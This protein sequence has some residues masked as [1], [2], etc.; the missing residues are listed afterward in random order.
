MGRRRT[1]TRANVRQTTGKSPSKWKAIKVVLFT[2][3]SF[4]FTWIPY[5][6]AST[7]YV[8]CDPQATPEFCTS[9]RIA[10]ASPLA[11]LGF[12]NSLLNPIIYAWWHNGFR[13]TMKKICCGRCLKA[14]EER[15]SSSSQRDRST[16]ATNANTTVLGP[17]ST[18]HSSEARPT[19]E[20]DTDL[21]QQ[22]SD[23]SDIESSKT[24]CGRAKINPLPDI[25]PTTRSSSPATF[26]TQS[27]ENGV[28]NRSRKYSS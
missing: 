4:V 7:M 27:P 11:I 24:P 8:N 10:I 19:S 13:E 17:S 1:K 26:M 28:S 3:G 6:I 23:N 12:A 9:L 15:G 22:S 21:A 5:F 25:S 18:S 20:S 14:S 2:T 16:P